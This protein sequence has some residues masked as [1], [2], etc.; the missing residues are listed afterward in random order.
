MPKIK[1]FKLRY[2]QIPTVF[3]LP[4]NLYIRQAAKNIPA[5]ALFRSQADQAEV[6]QVIMQV[7]LDL[8]RTRYV[9]LEGRTSREL[10]S[11]WL[12]V[13]Q[14]GDLVMPEGVFPSFTQGDSTA[15]NVSDIIHTTNLLI[16]LSGVNIK[17]FTQLHFDTKKIS[18]CYKNSLGQPCGLSILAAPNGD[19]EG[20]NKGWILSII[21]NTVGNYETRE[22]AVFATPEYVKAKA[23]SMVAMD[24]PESIEAELKTEINNNRIFNLIKGVFNPDGSLNE[25]NLK[26]LDSR[27]NNHSQNIDNRDTKQA[28][29]YSLTRFASKIKDVDLNRYLEKIQTRVDQ[30]IDFFTDMNFSRHLNELADR[31]A[32]SIT[33]Q[34]GVKKSADYISDALKQITYNF[35]QVD[36]LAD[37]QRKNNEMENTYRAISK[38]IQT[39]LETITFDGSR[40]DNARILLLGNLDVQKIKNRVVNFYNTAPSV[41]EYYHV[42]Q[43]ANQVLLDRLN[44]LKPSQ[45]PNFLLRNLGLLGVSLPFGACIGAVTL[46]LMGVVTPLTLILIAVGVTLAATAFIAGLLIFENETALNNEKTEL[47]SMESKLRTLHRNYVNEAEH[48]FQ[49]EISLDSFLAPEKPDFLS[50]ISTSKRK[51]LTPETVANAIW[52]RN[53][54]NA[55]NVAVGKSMFSLWAAKQGLDFGIEEVEEVLDRNYDMSR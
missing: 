33:K 37:D 10:K 14:T 42:K 40:A 53:N 32:L 2:E 13:D 46:F 35:A 24:T 7:D 3:S 48:G 47:L 50:G 23:H 36:S 44:L 31:V 12:V 54:M 43:L 15:E 11:D 22:L 51:P 55:E 39:D 41:S 17:S 6:D 9:D 16:P 5:K 8:E 20:K 29:L 49:A 28:Q 27:I 34:S 21:Q 25:E 45:G 1:K 26:I 52:R 18:F 30:D 4:E 19:S 38:K